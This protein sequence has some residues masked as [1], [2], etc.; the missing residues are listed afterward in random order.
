MT[1]G[2]LGIAFFSPFDNRRYFL[3]WRPIL[4]SPRAITRFFS[5]RGYAV[6]RSELLWIWIPAILFAGMVLTLKRRRREDAPAASN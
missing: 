4:V 3:P 5:P 1:N 6:F 2:G